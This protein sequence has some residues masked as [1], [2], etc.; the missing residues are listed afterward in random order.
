MRVKSKVLLTFFLAIMLLIG[1]LITISSQV[2][3]TKFYD[4]ELSQIKDAQQVIL[5]EIN[6]DTEALS[7]TTADWAAWGE[8]YDYIQN[9]NSS[10]AA[11]NFSYESLKNLP[12]DLIIYT[13]NNKIVHASAIEKEKIK[14]PSTDLLSEVLKQSNLLQVYSDYRNTKT[15]IEL[16]NHGVWIASAQP[17]SDSFQK[18]PARGTL[19]MLKRLD[20]AYFKNMLSRVRIKVSLK[21]VSNEKNEAIKKSES[22]IHKYS[23]IKIG[24]NKFLVYRIDHIPKTTIKG[25]EAF[26]TF[27]LVVVFFVSFILGLTYLVIEKKVLS[28]L[29]K[30]IDEINLLKVGNLT[31]ISMDKELTITEIQ[32]LVNTLNKLIS[33]VKDDYALLVQKGKFESLGLMAGGVAHEINNPITVIQMNT[34]KLLRQLKKNEDIDAQVLKKKLEKN[35]QHIDRVTNIILGMK[36]LSRHSIADSL[37]KVS[38]NEI[39]NDVSSLEAG[40]KSDKDITITYTKLEEDKFIEALPSQIIQVLINLIVN[41]SHAINGHDQKWIR[42]ETQCNSNFIQFKVIDSGNG[43]SKEIQEKIMAP[44]F[45][46]KEVGKGTGLGLSISQRIAHYHGGSLELDTDSRNTTFILNIPL[47]K[48]V[49]LEE[50]VS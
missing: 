24:S 14:K 22:I 7:L 10:Y 8:T 40:F 21:G 34:F 25:K 1:S 50:K 29:M 31:M 26:I 23:S 5:N 35:M 39:I 46:T 16:E 30:I 9:K 37:I 3:N 49:S 36:K 20:Q 42:L 6:K 28:E 17:I 4:L 19:I 11:E 15:I 13:N 44:F 47:V 43:I 27:T 12:I 32:D 2:F 18:A 33:R 48:I 41:S 38:V 45:T